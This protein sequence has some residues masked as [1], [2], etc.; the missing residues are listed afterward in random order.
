MKR[1]LTLRIDA[2]TVDEIDRVARLRGIS[3]NELADRY[4]AEGVRRD[5]FPQISFRDG[6]LGRR[7][8][9]LGTRLDVWQVVDT[10]RGH[11]NSI[12][13]AAAYLDL[14]VERVRAAVR[15]AAAHPG[16]IEDIATREAE[17]AARAEDLWRAEQDLL[18]P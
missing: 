11:G 9:L 10:V 8:A 5:E 1:H 4:L 7:A 2:P 17:A 16:E 12:E 18:A 3:R 13:D 6:A 15:Y 14:P